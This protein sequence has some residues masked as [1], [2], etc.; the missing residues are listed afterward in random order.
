[1]MKNTKGRLQ[2]SNGP[3]KPG[4]TSKE[5]TMK[6]DKMTK[7]NRQVIIIHLP[8]GKRCCFAALLLFIMP[9]ARRTA[10]HHSILTFSPKSV[11]GASVNIK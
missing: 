4:T 6:T 2:K 9:V 10:S 5:M 3:D 8:K 11:R 1:M 7:N